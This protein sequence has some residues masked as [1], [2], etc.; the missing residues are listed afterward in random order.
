MRSVEDAIAHR[1]VQARGRIREIETEYGPY[2][3][4]TNGITLG[5]GDASLDQ[6]APRLGAHNA[7]ILAG[8]GYDAAAQ[9]RLHDEGVI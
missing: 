2:R 5:H 1:Q 4:M 9:A 8:L 3:F 6:P 7:A